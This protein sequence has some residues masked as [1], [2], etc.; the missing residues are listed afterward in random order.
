MNVR[1]TPFYKRLIFNVLKVCQEANSDTLF[2]NNLFI[3]YF[4]ISIAIESSSS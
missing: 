3:N 1:T 4:L 2:I